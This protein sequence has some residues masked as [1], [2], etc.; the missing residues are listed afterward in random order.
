M[1]VSKKAQVNAQCDGL[2]FDI[3]AAILFPDVSRKKIKGIIDSGGAYLNKKRIKFAKD[4]VFE[5]NTIEIVFNEDQKNDSESQK[6][7]RILSG[8]NIL[9]ENEQFIIVNKPAG[10]ASQP[11]LTSNKETILYEISK[12]KQQPETKF[13]LV[14]RL[15]KDTSGLIVIAKSKQSQNYFETLFKDRKIQKKYLAICSGL[16]PQNNSSFEVNFPIKKHPNRNNT[17]VAIMK[18]Q[19]ETA[20]NFSASK[21]K[22]QVK[23]ASTNFKVLNVNLK[24]RVTCLLCL[25]K[26][27]RTHQ[28]RVHA[29]SVGL[30]LLG[31][32]TYA[33]NLLENPWKAYALR[34]MLHAFQ[35]KFVGP[36]AKSYSFVAPLPADFETCLKNLDLNIETELVANDKIF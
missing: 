14:H 23:E 28:I 11:T 29:V 9:F 36:D 7:K 16:P 27:G 35:L 12:L 33:Q 31:D 3:A 4:S 19:Q 8:E 6:E 22:S 18:F 15:D 13:F 17:Y 26:T 5:G 24:R 30:P 32:K 2:R 1:I 20:K 10:I 25:P 21:T 34:H